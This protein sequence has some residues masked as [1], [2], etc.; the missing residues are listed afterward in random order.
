MITRPDDGH[1]FDP[2][3]PLTVLL[4]PDPDYLALT[5]G[6]YEQLRRGAARRR[7]LRVAVGVGL[8]GVVAA[9]VALPLYLAEPGSP[10]APVTPLAPPPAG[11]PST[12]PTSSLPTPA[13]ATTR[14]TKDATARSTTRPT[15]TPG[16][17]TTAVPTAAA[18][19]RTTPTPT[20]T[21]PPRTGGAPAPRMMD[22]RR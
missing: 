15:A 7:M 13:P 5:P 16:A 17:P 4:R 14:P 6:R 10:A 12:G 8:S 19:P 18:P 22:P 20:T 2:D 11:R 9:L 21:A 1:D 3:D